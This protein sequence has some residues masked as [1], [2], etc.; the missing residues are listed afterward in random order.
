MPDDRIPFALT[1]AEMAWVLLAKVDHTP[2]AE[3]S[4]ARSVLARHIG[5]SG[6]TRAMLMFAECKIR[7]D[8]ELAEAAKA[9]RSVS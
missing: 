7:V 1:A 4:F 3:T 5:I 8:A 9:A 2:S 6:Q